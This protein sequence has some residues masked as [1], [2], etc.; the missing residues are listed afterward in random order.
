MTRAD[1]FRPAMG[2]E[3]EFISAWYRKDTDVMHQIM[4]DHGFTFCRTDDCL[5]CGYLACKKFDPWHFT[6]GCTCRNPA[7]GD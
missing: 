3:L 5:V 2:D 7:L 4:H 1:W 6:V